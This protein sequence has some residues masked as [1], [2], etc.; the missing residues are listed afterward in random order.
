[1]GYG[2]AKTSGINLI[3]NGARNARAGARIRGLFLGKHTYLQAVKVNV[4]L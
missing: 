2:H 4:N 1:M 3:T